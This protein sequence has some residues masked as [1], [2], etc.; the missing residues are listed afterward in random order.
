MVHQ[1]RRTPHVFFFLHGKRMA[2]QNN[3]ETD[4]PTKT[5]L[6]GIRAY[7]FVKRYHDIC[8][9]VYIYILYI[10]IYIYIYIYR[11]REREREI[12][13]YARTTPKSICR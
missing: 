4:V 12:F 10:Y 13:S 2:L 6:K 3:R 1:T 7:I 11:E 8:V 9:C 5:M